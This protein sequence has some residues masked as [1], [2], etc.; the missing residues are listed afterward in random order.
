MSASLTLRRAYFM[1]SSKWAAMISAMSSTSSS[2]MAS[3][4]SFLRLSRSMSFSMFSLM[5]YLHARWQIS[6]ISAPLK[7]WVYLARACK[8]TSLATGDFLRQALKI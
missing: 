4:L 1:D 3:G 7:P 8:S 5:A 6:V 2:S